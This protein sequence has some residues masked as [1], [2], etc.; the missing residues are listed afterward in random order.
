[1]LGSGVN[2]LP[3]EK[4]RNRRKVRAIQLY[5]EMSQIFA[6]FDEEEPKTP[7][8]HYRLKMGALLKASGGQLS[9]DDWDELDIWVASQSQEWRTIID[10]HARGSGLTPLT[11]EY[12]DGLRLPLVDAYFQ[13]DDDEVAKAP[14][15]MQAAYALWKASGRQEQGVVSRGLRPLLNKISR[16]K[17]R[18][19]HDNPEVDKFLYKFGMGG[20]PASPELRKR[21]FGRAMDVVDRSG[22][23]A[24]W[25]PI[26]L[27]EETRSTSI[28]ALANSSR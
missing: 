1:M 20:R 19:R 25:S 4:W 11:A 5:S 23:Q 3:P 8:D 12:Y 13:I 27:G 15:H 17:L 10:E 14:A 28:P 21:S 26:S 9:E 18:Y 2:S 6:D 7:V 22:M 16:A 24:P